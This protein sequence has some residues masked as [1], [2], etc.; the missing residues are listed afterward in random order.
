MSHFKGWW[1]GK[2]GDKV[3]IFPSNFVTNDEINNHDISQLEIDYEQLDVHE[4][5]G[6]GGFGKVYRAFYE[7]EEVAVKS[8]RH[9]DASGDIEMTRQ[10]ILQ[11]AR[12]FWVLCHKN[13]VELKGVCLKA[14]KLCMVMEYAKGGSLN[15][16][17]AGK[18][19]SPDILVN[20]AQ[21]I[22]E[23][24]NYLHTHA[25]IS[26]IHRDLKSS[27]GKSNKFAYPVYLH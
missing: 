16:V 8:A 11:E 9:I 13:I 12:L 18:Q 2:L 7:N 5:I 15:R 21:Q 17:L 25:P 19:I 14:P 26:V 3:G 1:T 23:G 27:N 20:W 6:V 24:M 22:A 10:S 4:V